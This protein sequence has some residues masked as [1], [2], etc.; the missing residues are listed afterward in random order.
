MCTKVVDLLLMIVDSKE[1]MKETKGWK[2]KKGKK[3]T[4]VDLSSPA[5]QA[6]HWNVSSSDDVVTFFPS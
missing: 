1:R 3:K 2:I 6:S 5:L 4:Q